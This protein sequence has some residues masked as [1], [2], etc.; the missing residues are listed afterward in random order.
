MTELSNNRLHFLKR[1][2]K[3]IGVATLFITLILLVVSK[4]DKSTSETGMILIPEGMLRTYDEA[5]FVDTHSIEHQTVPAT[6]E[7]SA[8]KHIDAFHMYVHPVTV[9]QFLEFI[10]ET[11]YITQAEK[12]G[13]FYQDI[14]GYNHYDLRMVPWEHDEK[15]SWQHPHGAN[16]NADHNHP[17]TQ[18]TYYDALAYCEWAGGTLPTEDQW[19]YAAQSAGTVT[20]TYPWGDTLYNDNGK[21]MANTWQPMATKE[22]EPLDG[23]LYTAPVGLTGKTPI[24]LTDMSGN[25]W[26]WTKTDYSPGLHDVD[27][28]LGAEVVE[29]EKVLR[30]GSFACHEN[31]C[32]GFSIPS[33]LHLDP[34]TPTYHIG[35]RC[36]KN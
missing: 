14:A 31:A 17:V 12:E 1:S 34:I 29:D 32:H 22:S 11:K 28:G 35:F 27:H 13:G 30:G 4:I 21:P 25:V 16:S 10:S 20:T 9:G 23:Y 8:E 33:R 18:V 19:E 36:V 2:L 6:Q 7:P 3:Y 5:I 24:G 26:E 15:A